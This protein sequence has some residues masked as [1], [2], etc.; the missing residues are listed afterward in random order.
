MFSIQDR[1]V[2]KLSVVKWIWCEVLGDIESFEVT[3]K[4][5]RKGC[6]NSSE[7]RKTAQ[8]IDRLLI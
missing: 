8:R 6:Y 5:G 1:G 7:P 4:G 3:R 2:V